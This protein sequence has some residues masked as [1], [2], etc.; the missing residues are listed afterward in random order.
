MVGGRTT[1]KDGHLAAGHDKNFKPAKDPHNKVKATYEYLPLGAP[2][3][4]SHKDED[5][6]VVIGPKNI[7][8]NPIKIGKV[9][10][11]TIIGDNIDYM[12]EDYDA[13]KKIAIAERKYHEQKV[14]EKPF[15]QRARHTE[16][17]NKPQAVYME[18]PPIP[19]RAPKPKVV[20]PNI[21]DDKPFKP[22]HPPKRGINATIEKFPE[23]I[24]NPPKEKKR[25]KLEDG[26]EEDDRKGFKVT[27]KGLSRPQPSVAT[28]IRNLKASYPMAFRK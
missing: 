21:H 10:K 15:L 5:G 8:T 25:V 14:Q 11:G 27:Y 23:Y 22:S 19:P 13:K 12:P 18:D 9:G 3:K 16:V 17:F 2:V 24:P 28:N 26:Q 1:V 7:L 20:A 6:A 4:K